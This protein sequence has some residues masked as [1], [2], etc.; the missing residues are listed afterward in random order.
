MRA[1]L[2]FRKTL[3]ILLF[4]MVPFI[5]LFS[6]TNSSYAQNLNG[7]TIT[8]SPVFLDLYGNPG[9]ST[10][11]VLH[12]ENNESNPIR[13]N[14]KL[15]EFKAYGLNGQAQLYT[16]PNNTPSLSWVHFSTTSFVA[17]PNVWNSVTM[18]INLPKDA[19]LGYYYGVIFAPQTLI[20]TSTNAKVQGENAILILLDA[21]S[22]NA[23]VQLAISS[24]KATQG[25]YQFLPATFDVNVKNMGN[26]FAVPQGNIYISRTPNGPVLASL[27]INSSGGNVLPGTTRQ[28]QVSWNNG[29]PNYQTQRLDGQIIT[30]SNGQPSTTL[31]WNLKNINEIRLG[32]YYAK[33]VLVYNN[34]VRDIP[35]SSILS[36]WVLPWI[37]IVLIL[38][39]ITVL[40]FGVW[41]FVHFIIRG[42][43]GEQNHKAKYTIRKK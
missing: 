32:K 25:L 7:S 28:F 30:G 42:F 37:L 39:G 33:L 23:N 17:E 40:G 5:G 20:T 9:Q 6:L 35:T 24:F 16:P 31:T 8:T 14:V 12:V 18:T 34:G 36:F 41:S 15:E 10:S 22:K 11:T 2:G 29:F 43:R 4:G 3:T 26:I 19:S 21:H 13:I 27:P 38:L 1:L